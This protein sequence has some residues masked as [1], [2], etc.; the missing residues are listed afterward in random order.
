MNYQIKEYCKKAGDILIFHGPVIEEGFSSAGK[1]ERR[2][3]IQFESKSQSTYE[4]EFNIPEGYRLYYLPEPVEI[5]NAYFD[6]LSTFL[7]KGTRI[8]H[9]VKFIKKTV[10]V[11]IENYVDFHE[12]CQKVEKTFDWYVLFKK[13]L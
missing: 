3:P 8:I 13:I 10:Q 7:E 4:V 12:S 11:P 6:C 2:Y 5:R 9:Q 1:E